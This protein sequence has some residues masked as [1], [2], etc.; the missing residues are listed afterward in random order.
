MKQLWISYVSHVTRLFQSSYDS[1][2]LPY[3]RDRIFA[4]M[5]IYILPLSIIALIPGLLLS[6]KY[7]LYGIFFGDI[8]VFALVFC[9]GFLPKISLNARKILFGIAVYTVALT[10]LYYLGSFGPGLVYLLAITFFVS[11]TYPR[12]QALWTAWINLG[13]CLLYGLLIPYNIFESETLSLFDRQL[14]WFGISSNMIF[15]S[16]LFPFLVP[17]LYTGLQ[18]HIESQNRLEKELKQEQM[19]LRESMRKLED[20][21]VELE[22]YAFIA[23]HDLQEPLRTITSF[24]TLLKE[25]QADKFDEKGLKYLRLAL[26][27][28]QNMRMTVQDLLEFS[29]IGE[30]NPE[31]RNVDINEV[32]EVIQSLLNKTISEQKATIQVESLPVIK[33]NQRLISQVFLNLITNALKY[34]KPGV[35]PVVK[36]G[37]VFNEEYWHFYVSDNGIG[38]EEE[39]FEKIFVIFQRLHDKN[40]YSGTGIGLAI[41][42][43][44]SDNFGGKVWVESI[45]NEGSIFHIQIPRI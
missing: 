38:I 33:T 12:K 6:Y 10:M 35:P 13:I 9:C 31:F 14:N 7:E 8:I 28:A 23:S 29:S 1:K 44:I 19:K 17:R 34:S 30:E 26:E 32:I 4:D 36:I 41:V 3:W 45:V 24:L 15:L 18:T 27:G 2:T 20:K 39:Y 43:K 16:F 37:Q 42:K 25:R 22:Q 11:L 21:N 5:I 40:I